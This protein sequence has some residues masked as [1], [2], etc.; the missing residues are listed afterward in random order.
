M[1]SH[2]N[3]SGI[4]LVK[5]TP[6]NRT[7]ITSKAAEG[8]NDDFIFAATEAIPADFSNIEYTPILKFPPALSKTCQITQDIVDK[9]NIFVKE[10]PLPQNLLVIAPGNTFWH[11]IADYSIIKGVFSNSGLGRGNKKLLDKM[12]KMGIFVPLKE[13]RR[14]EYKLTPLGFALSE[15]AYASI[16]FE[17]KTLKEIYE[18]VDNKKNKFGLKTMNSE[19][20]FC[21]TV[22]GKDIYHVSNTGISMLG[23]ETLFKKIVIL[24]HLEH[25]WVKNENEFLKKVDFNSKDEQAKNAAKTIVNS[26]KK[27][28]LKLGPFLSNKTDQDLLTAFNIKE[29]TYICNLSYRHVSYFSKKFGPDIELRVNRE[30]IDFMSNNIVNK[31]K[32]EIEPEVPNFHHNYD[33]MPIPVTVINNNEVVGSFTAE[34]ISKELSEYYKRKFR[35]HGNT[36]GLGHAALPIF[37]KLGKI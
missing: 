8:D 30:K 2:K 5:K 16:K 23:D 7:V 9:F 34:V 37:Q 26:L 6:L 14:T 32:K 22:S 28:N 11:L 3:I 10:Y 4:K 24:P 18:E 36:L 15:L 17:T 35:T 25:P 13:N 29:N 20:V 33:M 12:V 21:T 31:L 27:S 1:S 19:R